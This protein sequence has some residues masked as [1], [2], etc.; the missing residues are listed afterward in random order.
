MDLFV[1]IHQEVNSFIP[2]RAGDMSECAKWFQMGDPDSAQSCVMQIASEKQ[3]FLCFQAPRI[4]NTGLI[5]LLGNKRQITHLPSLG[6]RIFFCKMRV[7]TR[8]SLAYLQAMRVLN[9]MTECM[10]QN[11]LCFLILCR[12]RI[13]S[14]AF[15]VTC[16]FA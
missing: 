13:F 15:K 5:I 1:E 12:C 9:S 16:F 14:L 4:G 10:V 8:C 2:L 3:F 6:L 7:N 11:L